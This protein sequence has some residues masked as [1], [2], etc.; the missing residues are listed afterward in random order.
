MAEA[1]EGR[2]RRSR[3]TLVVSG[4]SVVVLLVL[5]AAVLVVRPGP[6]EGWLSA[7]PSAQPR[8]VPTPDPT[9]TPV[10]V[11]AEAGAT[12]PTASGVAA[13]IGPLVSAK[14]LGT[15]NISVVDGLTGDVLFEKNAGTMTTPA[16]T[17]KL[18][19]AA[20]V[21][22]ARGPAYRLT[23]RVVAGAKPGEVVLIGGGDPTLAVDADDQ[24]PG[25]AR[26]D[27]LAAQ[28]KQ[29][30]GAQQP[31]RVIV[32]T[33]LYTGPEMGTG[34]DGGLISG[35]QVARIQA[36]MTNAGRV[37]PVHN[38]R[39][40]DRR[41]TDPALAAGRAFAQ[42]LGLPES[43][44]SRGKAPAGTQLGAV[45]SPPLVHIVDW[46]L[47]QSDNVLAEAMARQVALAAGQPASFD[48]AAKAMGDKLDELGLPG[49]EA[50][51]Y[52][53][54]GLSRHNGISPELLTDVLSLA[55][56]GKNPQVSS[57]LGGLP[58]A[59]W[60][61]TLRTRFATPE[62]NQAGQGIVRAKT[63]SLSGV[64]TMAGQLMTRDGR[65]LLFA[66]MATGA[67]AIEARAALDKLATTLVSCGCS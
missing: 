16:S 59:G 49:E 7:K 56:S 36:L 22:A 40:G 18:L 44:V 43:A 23:T 65:L 38:E 58:V 15:A 64:N 45:Q 24:F 46:M 3:R 63:G 51:L 41:F 50:D 33:S 53:A 12:A 30:L 1:A 14:S 11:A 28:V 55:A 9:P 66:F 6:V 42:Q 5:A 67:N 19:T 17:T 25:A 29:A 26:L 8:V 57:M 2:K 37:E 48:G 52:D 27:K 54:S 61:G 31:T 47:E 39:G 13:A 34:W 20:T 35:G 32:D 21:L 62:P 4:L 10:L 60:S